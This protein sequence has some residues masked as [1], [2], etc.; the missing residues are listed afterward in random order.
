MTPVVSIHHQLMGSRNQFETI[1]VIKVLRYVLAKR[2]SCTSGGNTPAMS[3]VG[4]RPEQVAHGTLVGHFNL[5]IDLPYLLESIEVW[6]QSSMQTE[7]LILHNS[8]KGKEIEEISVIFPDVCI[9]VFPEALVI[10]AIDLCNLSALVIA[11][12]NR[13][14]I[15]KADFEAD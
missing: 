15:L 6:R 7:N 3:V 12:K 8:R 13:N 2:K 11:S 9:S 14:S 4:V 5:S 10:E 1:R